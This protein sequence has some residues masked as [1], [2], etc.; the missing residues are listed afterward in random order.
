MIFKD[1]VKIT[2]FDIEERLGQNCVSVFVGDFRPYRGRDKNWHRQICEFRHIGPK[3]HSQ[4]GAGNWRTDF[5]TAYHR[6]VSHSN[7]L[8]IPD[9]YKNSIGLFS[10]CAL[11]RSIISSIFLSIVL[12]KNAICQ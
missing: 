3:H 10:N 6:F 9:R 8:L 12:I 7:R 4:S 2:K 11:R 1:W 5:D